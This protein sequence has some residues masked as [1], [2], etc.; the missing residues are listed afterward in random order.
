MSETTTFDIGNLKPAKEELTGADLI[1]AK[2]VKVTL[3]AYIAGAMSVLKPDEEWTDEYAKLRVVECFRPDA[4]YGEYGCEF[5]GKQE[6]DCVN[7]SSD[8]ESEK[9][10]K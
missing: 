7:Y 10:S 8:E 3:D 4:E 1:V 5:C 9:G 6:C 2:L